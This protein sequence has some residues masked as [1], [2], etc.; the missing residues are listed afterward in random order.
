ML[1]CARE[2]L[3]APLPVSFEA[4][5]ALVERVQG[6]RFRGLVE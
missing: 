6:V 3:A 1:S 5:S 4:L 2:D